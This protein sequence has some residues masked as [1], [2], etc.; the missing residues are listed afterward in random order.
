MAIFNIVFNI[1]VFTVGLWLVFYD[2]EDRFTFSAKRLL[3]PTLVGCALSIAVYFTALRL[4]APIEN[5]MSAVG[6]M[7]TPLAMFVIGSTL[8]MMNARE[9]FG[10]RRAYV[11]CLVKQ[12]ALPLAGWFVLRALVGD[13]MI[14]DIAFFMLAL[15]SANVAV[16]F[17]T[18]Y[19]VNE[20]T[21]AKNVLL[22]TV[23]AIISIPLLAFICFR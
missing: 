12:L 23:A 4:P 1:A 17:A 15:P 6:G 8:A 14:R 13:E 21:A 10:D 2:R 5:V 3:S 22:T 20:D 11:F 19:G 7:T 18:E 9:L 16:M